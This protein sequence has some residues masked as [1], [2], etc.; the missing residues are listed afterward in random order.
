MASSSALSTEQLAC[1]YPERP[2]LRDIAITFAKGT[3]TAILGPNGSGKSTLLKTL[4]GEL[5]PL[6]GKVLLVQGDLATLSVRQIATLLSVVPQQEHIPFRFTAR[7]VVT[8]GRYA[9]SAGILDTAE[10][11]TAAEEAMR[12]TDCLHLAERPITELSG[13][14][15]QRV[16]LARALAQDTDIVVLDEPTTHLDIT[17]QL[18]LCRIVREMVRDGKTVIAAMHDLNLV[19][20]FASKAALLGD[21]GVVALDETEV[22]LN[23]PR[24]DE[25]YGVAFRR[26]TDG[27]RTVVLP[28]SAL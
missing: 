22:V 16:L 18:D 24:L 17:H 27:G 13:G 1:G 20:Q 8:M 11:R 4:T 6:S 2:V 9:Q 5:A 15:R 12:Y 19:G 7:E 21:G 3:A 26:I 28:P 23:S 14:E 25:V 10:D